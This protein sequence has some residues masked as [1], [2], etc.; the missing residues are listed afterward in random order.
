[1]LEYWEFA[2]KLESVVRR[3]DMFGKSRE[4]ILEELTD[5]ADNYKTVANYMEQ[6]MANDLTSEMEA[7]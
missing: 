7:A 5:I 2:K 1:M 6:Q 3:A 4:D